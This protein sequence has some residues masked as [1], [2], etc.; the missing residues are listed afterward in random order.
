MFVWA[1]VFRSR[2]AENDCVA[3]ET[4]RA[5]AKATICKEHGDVWVSGLLLNR[6]SGRRDKLK[7]EQ[8]ATCY[9]AL[10]EIVGGDTS[11]WEGSF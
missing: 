7:G 1:Y 9:V 6:K 10:L 5:A 3:D 2:H 8:E 4:G 11:I